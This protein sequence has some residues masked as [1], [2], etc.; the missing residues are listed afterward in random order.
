M[1]KSMKIATLG[2]LLIA[3]PL[4]AN[5]APGSRHFDREEIRIGNTFT[6]GI[7]KRI[8]RQRKRIRR[9]RRSGDLTFG[10]FQRLRFG[11]ARIRA[12]RQFAKFDGHVSRNERRRLHRM[13]NRHSRKIN[14][15]RNNHRVA[16]GGFGF[17]VSF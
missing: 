11:L 7:D 12:A 16:G 3:T 1:L 2:A 14:R 6:P 5:A 9:G 10:E 13:L 17:N 15:L 4:V 8:K